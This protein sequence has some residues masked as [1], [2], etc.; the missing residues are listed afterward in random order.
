MTIKF[1]I[2]FLNIENEWKQSSF[3]VQ[4]KYN[5]F[6][7]ENIIQYNFFLWRVQ[8]DITTRIILK[9]KGISKITNN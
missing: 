5:F 7:F 1:I 8:T 4:E 6:Y 9:S 2:R 3:L